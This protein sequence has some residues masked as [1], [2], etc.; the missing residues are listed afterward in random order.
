MNALDFCKGMEI[1]LTAWKAKLY[2]VI[3]KIDRL[4][5]GEKGKMLMN[6]QDLNM[7]LT[8]MEDKIESLKTEC[9]SDWSPQKKKIDDAHVD[10][11]SKYEETMAYIGKAS[12]V[13][14]PG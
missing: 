4:S 6:I 1:E 7:A 9:P 10:M 5:T 3:R 13:S 11:R 2:D 12:P 14:I 8:E